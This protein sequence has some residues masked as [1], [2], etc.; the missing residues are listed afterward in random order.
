MLWWAQTWQQFN[1]YLI[2]EEGLCCDAGKGLSA[3]SFKGI[4][5]SHP[6]SEITL[7]FPLFIYLFFEITLS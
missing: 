7:F 3:F 1:I 4:L 2:L 6:Y 5:S